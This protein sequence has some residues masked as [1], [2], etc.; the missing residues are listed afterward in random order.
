MSILF[1]T[2]AGIYEIALQSTTTFKR[3]LAELRIVLRKTTVLP[4]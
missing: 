3:R 4:Q 2:S 1:L